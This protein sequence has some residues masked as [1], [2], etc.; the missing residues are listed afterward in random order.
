M[1]SANAL[2]FFTAL[3]VNNSDPQPFQPAGSLYQAIANYCLKHNALIL[4]CHLNKSA[5][6]TPMF[7]PRMKTK[8][9]HLDISEKPDVVRFEQVENNVSY[10]NYYLGHCLE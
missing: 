5:T 1:L 3:P 9:K 2:L 10:S 6:K 8:C 4:K 7:V